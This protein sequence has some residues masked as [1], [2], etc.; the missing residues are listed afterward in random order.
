MI[1]LSGEAA[2]RFE[3]G[4][5]FYAVAL[6]MGEERSHAPAAVTAAC[7]AIRCFLLVVEAATARRVPD[8]GGELARLRE[9]C[10][11]LLNLRQDPADARDHALA[12]ARLARDQASRLLALMAGGPA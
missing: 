6:A 7:D 2:S 3:D 1:G 8:P 11:A 5:R 10:G 4:L 9:Q 12:A